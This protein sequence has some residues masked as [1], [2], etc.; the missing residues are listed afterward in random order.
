MMLE[1]E[2]LILRPIEESDAL[3]LFPI[4]NDPDVASGLLTMPHPYPEDG[5]VPWIRKA[6][7]AMGRKEQYHM[8][9]VLKEPGL[10]MG[11]CSLSD[12]SWEHANAELGYWLGKKY[13]GRGYMT[14]AVTGIVRFGFEELGLERIYACCFANNPASARVL[15]KVGFR[16]EGC[17]R[18][19]YKK[20]SEFVDMRHFGMIRQDFIE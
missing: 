16:Y 8:V 9:I 13:W 19:E 1:T 4:I 10:P 6:Q 2:R 11:V 15:E 3:A 17:A 7:E 18:H 5:L 12:L 14:E 20:D